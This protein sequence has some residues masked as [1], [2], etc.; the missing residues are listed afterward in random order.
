MFLNMVYFS[1]LPV[2]VQANTIKCIGK[3]SFL[4]A[5]QRNTGKWHA[6]ATS[7]VTSWSISTNPNTCE[8]QRLA[9][10]VLLLSQFVILPD[11]TD[12]GQGDS[13]FDF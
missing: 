5:V 6:K 1:L 7:L 13:I 3:G 10:K 9:T 4:N 12:I 11:F 2:V 8:S